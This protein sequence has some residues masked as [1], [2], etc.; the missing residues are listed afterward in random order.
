[1]EML[2]EN[3]NV[4]PQNHQQSTPFIKTYNHGDGK[5]FDPSKVASLE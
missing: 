1:M 3:Q 2:G 4:A 5:I